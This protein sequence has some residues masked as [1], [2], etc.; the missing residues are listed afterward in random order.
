MADHIG[1]WIQS[2]RRRLTIKFRLYLTAA[3]IL[4]I[5]LVIGL[6][7]QGM[8]R[9]A[10]EYE[11]ALH[12]I[13]SIRHNQ[14][15]LSNTEKNFQLFDTKTPEFFQSGSSPHLIAF[16]EK[17]SQTLGMVD[18]LQTQGFI[19]EIG[20]SSDIASL[21]EAILDY[22]DTF[23]ELN[24]VTL[25]KGFKEFGLIGQMREIIRGSESRIDESQNFELMVGIL[26]LRRNEKDY[27]LRKDIRYSDEFNFNTEE[28]IRKIQSFSDSIHF[29]QIYKQKAFF[30]SDLRA[31]QDLFAQIVE[32]D[33]LIGY[34]ENQGL[35]KILSRQNS[36]VENLLTKM[37]DSIR[38]QTEMAVN[39][40]IR[41]ILLIGIILSIGIIF[42]LVSI[43][44]H[45]VDSLTYLKGYITRLGKGE[46][47]EEILA[48]K[49]DEIGEMIGSINNLTQNLK[50]T[51]EFAIE[52]G[53]GN[54]DTNVNVFGNKGDLGGSL[55]EMRNQLA[56][57]NEEQKRNEDERQKRSWATE[58]IAIFS[59]I[60]RDTDTDMDKFSF[61]L[62]KKLVEY[63]H[64][65]QGGIY[66]LNDDDLE[67]EYFELKSAIAFGK[68]KLMKSKVVPGADLVGKC[69]QEK[70]TIHLRDLP[71]QYA[72]IQSSLG[73]MPTR[74]IVIFP[75][76]L[77]D[78]LMGIVELGSSYPF[79][80]QEIDFLEKLGKNIATTIASIK[81]SGRTMLLLKQTQEQAARMKEQEEELRQSV[82]EMEATQ[83]EAT[84]REAELR[85]IVGALQ[86]IFLVVEFDMDGTVLEANDKFLEFFGLSHK[87]YIGK[88]HSE[89]TVRNEPVENYKEFWAK[90]RRGETL[91]DIQYVELPNG[92]E[93]WLSE[94]YTPILDARGT[95]V[96]VLNIAFDLTDSKLQ[97][98]QIRK[99][100][101]E[102]R[103]QEVS[104]N[105]N[106]EEML[107]QLD[108]IQ[109]EK[110]SA[111]KKLEMAMRKVAEL[112]KQI[113]QLE[114]KL[115]L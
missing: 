17:L 101:E 18:E 97:E 52:V 24:E 39:R 20:I 108:T 93:F 14:L 55:V 26:T 42:L 2:Q 9:K 45:I 5:L 35:T 51:R 99:Q 74:H 59:E 80:N 85:S 113:R 96:R 72:F 104:M 73:E 46:L 68:K 34:N 91:M 94:I 107:K 7:T 112:N 70:S 44:Q 81:N 29:P 98:R 40:I 53:K 102:L 21:K 6:V 78:K 65:L 67:S 49:E 23:R 56:K 19:G 10:F 41:N 86:Q 111:D 31:Y 79:E 28:L 103:A 3:G 33:E 4:A 48:T 61:E 109:A 82:E 43:T 63:L 84:R 77:H 58:G 11:D 75:L 106:M 105:Q 95:P 38:L 36:R 8:V 32:R 83:E 64:A 114:G 47:P 60:M 92:K 50:N 69:A 110:E 87:D 89:F 88:S 37:S 54:L 62:L 115:K 30:I 25:K 22:R 90:L 1:A 100:A 15:Q 27:L 16:E 12:Q 71:S 76:L 13:S 66:I 57:L